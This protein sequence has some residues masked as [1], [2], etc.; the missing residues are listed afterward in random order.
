MSSHITVYVKPLI[1]GFIISPFSSLLAFIVVRS[2]NRVSFHY[3][4][5]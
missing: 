4:I 3:L 1:E 2:T 5:S